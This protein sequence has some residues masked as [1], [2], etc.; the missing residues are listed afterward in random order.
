MAIGSTVV[1]PKPTSRA[2]GSFGGVS[3]SVTARSGGKRTIPSI[4]L[5]GACSFTG[6]LRGLPCDWFYAVTSLVRTIAK[7]G[8][9]RL[10]GGYWPPDSLHAA[11]KSHYAMLNSTVL[12]GNCP[13]H[14]L[15]TL[16]FTQRCSNG[17]PIRATNPRCGKWN[18]NGYGGWCIC[19]T[20]AAGRMAALPA[21]A[22]QRERL[23]R[24][25]ADLWSPAIG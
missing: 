18:R 25:F 8:K 23:I 13:R 10:A 11:C 17:A 2:C 4:R 5:I 24:V 20:Q 22:V 16:T 6:R 19:R 14:L 15:V 9:A 3:K 1:I 12:P 7:G 21:I